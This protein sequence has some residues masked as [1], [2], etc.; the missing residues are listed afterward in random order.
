MPQRRPGRYIHYVPPIFAYP[1]PARNPAHPIDLSKKLDVLGPKQRHL[2]KNKGIDTVHIAVSERRIRILAQE[3]E[4]L[5][6]R[7][8]V[9]CGPL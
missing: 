4:L 7:R 3:K 8:H 2:C 5:G 9:E 6:R 1:V